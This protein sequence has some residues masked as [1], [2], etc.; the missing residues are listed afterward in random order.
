MKGSLPPFSPPKKDML[1][2]TQHDNKPA[3]STWARDNLE[4][5]AHDLWDD[6][7]KLRE[8]L[9]HLKLEILDLKRSLEDDLR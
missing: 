1:R 9:S 5:I 7:K 2:T 4:R 6:N 3:F 8:Q